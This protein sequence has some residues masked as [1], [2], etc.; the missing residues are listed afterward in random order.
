MFSIAFSVM[1]DSFLFTVRKERYLIAFRL[2]QILLFPALMYFYGG[3]SLRASLNVFF[4]IGLLYTF[5]VWLSFL[6]S[7][8]P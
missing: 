1:P 7:E 5:L 2:L 4:A 6:T 3:E 8:A